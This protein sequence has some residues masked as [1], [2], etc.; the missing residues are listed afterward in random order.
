M[1]TAEEVNSVHELFLFLHKLKVIGTVSTET[2]STPLSE[3]GKPNRYTLIFTGYDHTTKNQVSPEEKL[4][5]YFRA[6]EALNQV[7]DDFCNE[8]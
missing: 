3:F 5:A 7:L 2:K 4:A 8:Q 6:S 1:L